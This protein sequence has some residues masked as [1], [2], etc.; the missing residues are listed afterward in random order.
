MMANKT[1]G[2]IMKLFEKKPKD[3]RVVAETNKVY[4]VG[5]FVMT[6]GI[7]IDL[8]M[9]FASANGEVQ[10][11]RPVEF[12]TF[13]LAQVVCLALLVRKGMADDGR[14]AEADVF[15]KKYYALTSL[16]GGAG[17]AILFLVC[18]MLMFPHWEFGVKAFVMVM[19]MCCG[20][21]MLTAAVTVYALQYLL[22]RMAKRRR[23]QMNSEDDE[24]KM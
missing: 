4:K 18:K 6:I 7:I 5:F 17:A 3:E 15:P 8:Y 9:Q 24:M 23:D 11:V 12:V 19:G 13:M 21:I 14:F 1:E 22:F 2:S 16:A 20:F 10:F